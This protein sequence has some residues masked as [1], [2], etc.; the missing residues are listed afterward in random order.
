MMQPPAAFAGLEDLLG[1]AQ[2]HG[3]DMRP[4]LLRVLT[5]L[6]LQRATHTAE[7]ERYF[8]ELALR[9]ID[10]TNVEA[11]AALATRLASYASP[12]RAVIERLARDVVEVAAPI[13]KHPTCLTAAD[14]AAIAQSCGGAHAEMIAALPPAAP[15]AH[16]SDAAAEAGDLAELFYAAGSPERRLILINLDYS[17]LPSTPPPAGMQRSDV[18]R[19]ES[20]VL[21]HNT[22]AV[23]RELER[24]LGVSRVQA[25]RIVD[26][27][28]GE[29][30]VVAAKAMNMPS[31]VLQRLLLFMNP[32]VGQSV[33]RVYQLAELF[34]EIT[35]D[36]ARRLVAIWRTAER[37]HSSPD[38]Y[39]TVPWRAAAENARRAL[40][41]LSRARTTV[42][43]RQTAEKMP[44]LR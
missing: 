17:A 14:R 43:G 13:L 21:Q 37:G 34:G 1:P 23:V 11:R 16:A 15:P 29:P 36:A 19:L 26:D 28:L 8:T 20:F 10:A 31:D 4:T 38:R 18:W 24:A 5:D 40:S 41:E 44:K 35:V 2:G 32:R 6:Y 7:D 3:I 9:L 22:E 12:P 30:V 33:D 25:R 42:D 27:E 39:E